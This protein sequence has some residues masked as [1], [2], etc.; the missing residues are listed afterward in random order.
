MNIELIT[1]KTNQLLSGHCAPEL[2][3]AAKAWLAAVGTDAEEEASQNYLTEIKDCVMPVDALID[4]M[5][6]DMAAEKFGPEMAGNILAHGKELKA[7]GAKYCD[8]PACSLA[9]EIWD[10]LEEDV[11]ERITLDFEDNTSVEC[12]VIGVFDVEDKMCIA[13]LPDDGTEE[14]LIYGYEDVAEDEFRLYDLTDEEFETAVNV[15]DGLL[16]E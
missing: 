14:I 10:L 5:G 3:E 2:A 16:E 7:Q 1:E 8:C 13:L 12:D 11:I 6:S 9:V 15:F 4:F